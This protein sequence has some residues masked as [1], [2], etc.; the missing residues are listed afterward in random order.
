LPR[1]DG[2]E[3]GTI[4]A[5]IAR[6]VAADP[7]V[8]VVLV[9]LT[10]IPNYEQSVTALADGLRAGGKPTLFVVT[11]GSVATGVRAIIRERGICYCDRLDDGFRL[12]DAWFSYRPDD[13]PL[14][15][16]PA[17]PA[18]P[19][20]PHSG[21]LSE[22]EAKGLLAA[23]GL[24]VT[25]ERPVRS[26]A[27]AGAASDAIGYPV[28]LKGVSHTVVHKSDAGLVRLDLADRAAVEAAFAEVSGTLRRLDPAAE[29]CVVAEMVKGGLEL[30]LGVKRDPQFGPVVMVGAGGVLVELMG[31]VEV[32]LA[33][34]SAER[35][36]AMLKRLKIWPLLQGFR[37][38]KR[39]DIGAVVDALV[40]LGQ[41]AASLDERLLELD[42]NPLLVGSE[43][44]GAIAADARAVVS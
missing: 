34:L 4:A 16:P 40:K 39:R 12:L 1:Q 20:L 44:E 25:R 24:R 27:E 18:A 2:G 5:P 43:G 11:P 26:A 31:D 37:G 41:L 15:P 32:A 35:A 30:I 17:L 33:P 14:E 28:V 6:A 3:A 42:I 36:E 29:S 19:S 38:Q 7:D 23:A 8:A 13:R 9:P 22:P 10:T 21:Y